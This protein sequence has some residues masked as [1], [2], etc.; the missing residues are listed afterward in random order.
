MLGKK[1]SILIDITRLIGFLLEEKLATGVERVLLA[2][3]K[4]FYGDSLAIFKLFGNFYVLN[5]KSSKRLFRF[6]LD[7]K[8][9]RSRVYTIIFYISLLIGIRLKPDITGSKLINVGISNIRSLDKLI[10]KYKLFCIFMVHDL[11]P[12]QFPEYNNGKNSSFKKKIDLMLELSNVIV[13]NSKDTENSVIQYTRANKIRTPYILTAL[14]G[15]ELYATKDEKNLKLPEEHINKPYFVIISTIEP[16]KNH[17]MLL[18]IWRR[19]IMTNENT[20]P[21]LII[22]GKRGWRC[23]NVTDMLDDCKVLKGHVFEIS[24]CCDSILQAYLKHS[25]A[26]LFPSFA[27]GFGLPIIES[28]N[29]S[30]PVIVSDIPV[31]HEIAGDIPEYIDPLDTLGWLNMIVEYSLINGIKRKQQ[32]KRMRGYKAPTWDEHFKIIESIMQS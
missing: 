4:Y 5:D 32:L 8:K 29:L 31:F 26:L 7:N 22:I 11:I 18:N 28:L 6:I 16:R 20:A 1:Y 14:L 17:I 12:L 19:M 21:N 24:N 9:K 15:T 10:H 30:T 13:A 2:Y 23:D 25:Q 27:E 3:V